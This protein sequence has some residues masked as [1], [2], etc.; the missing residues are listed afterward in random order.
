MK[1]IEKIGHSIRIGFNLTNAFKKR[2][3]KRQST[4]SRT[5]KKERFS[6]KNMK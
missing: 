1:R 4:R 5:E 2:K 6:N 3:K